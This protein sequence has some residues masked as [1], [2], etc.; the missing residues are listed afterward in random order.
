MGKKPLPRSIRDRKI[1]F[2]LGP[3]GVGKSSVAQALAGNDCTHLSQ[4]GVLD[5]INF[6]A[7]HREWKSELLLSACLILECPCFLNRR[8]AAL[9]G[10]QELLRMRAG[11]ERRTW[12]IE[13]Q[14]GTAMDQ[15]MGAVHPGYRATLVLRF[16]VGRG[17]LR[18]AKRICNDLGIPN[19]RA[20]ATVHIDPWSY[21]TVRQVL[22]EME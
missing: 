5:A 14:S 3:T 12:V 4:K 1:V 9:D 10:L 11:G 15:V 7:R 2:I 16:P 8:P 20:A 19:S 13:A 22:S 17:R 21:E 6:N 18:F